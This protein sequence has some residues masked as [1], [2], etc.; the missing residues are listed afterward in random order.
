MVLDMNAIT[1]LQ[2]FIPTKENLAGIQQFFEVEGG[3][4]EDLADADL[5]LLELA[6]VSFLSLRLKAFGLMLQFPS[7]YQECKQ[8]RK[9]KKTTKKKIA[10]SNFL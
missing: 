3:T 7:K 2:G 4:R 1:Q 5:F 8:V 6:K 10:L 9:S